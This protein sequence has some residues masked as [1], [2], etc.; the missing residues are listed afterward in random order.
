[1]LDFYCPA[2]RLVVEV[3]G[4]QHFE[5]ARIRLD[6]ARTKYLEN[7]GLR[8]LRFTN[9]EVLREAGS[10]LNAIHLAMEHPSP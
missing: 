4:G 5:P 7:S 10:V 6:E 9:L 2:A 8:V 1:M 3:D